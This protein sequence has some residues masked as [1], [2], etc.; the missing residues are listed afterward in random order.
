M[1]CPQHLAFAKLFKTTIPQGQR[2]AWCS[3]SAHFSCSC[4]YVSLLQGQEVA[5]MQC[6]LQ[7]GEK[8]G[9]EAIVAETV[10]GA[11]GYVVLQRED[12]VYS[13]TSPLEI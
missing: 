11:K 4:S 6:I 13:F 5:K 12:T 10:G 3:L 2:K 9:G 8:A 7:V 1:F